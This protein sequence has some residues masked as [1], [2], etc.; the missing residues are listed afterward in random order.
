[1]LE[2]GAYELALSRREAEILLRAAHVELEDVEATLA[3]LGIWSAIQA[4]EILGCARR[5]SPSAAVAT[6]VGAYVV[7]EHERVIEEQ[8]RGNPLKAE[9]VR[10][11]IEARYERSNDFVPMR[12]G[13]TS[14]ST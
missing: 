10:R 11:S 1:M 7:A 3:P 13:A 9:A 8:A 14:M 2:I 5:N 4:S 12:L 6:S